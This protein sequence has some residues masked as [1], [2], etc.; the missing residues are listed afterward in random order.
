MLRLL[1]LQLHK[2]HKVS[3]NIENMLD[4]NKKLYIDQSFPVI[5][6]S[7]SIDFCHAV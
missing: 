6:I 3:T 7:I 2:F 1:I 4:D 5:I